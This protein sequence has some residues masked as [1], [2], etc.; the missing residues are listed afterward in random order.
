MQQVFNAV[1]FTKK[2]HVKLRLRVF[3]PEQAT[4]EF[5]KSCRF[6]DTDG[7]TEKVERTAPGLLSGAPPLTKLSGRVTEEKWDRLMEGGR[8][9]IP[10]LSMAEDDIE[11]TC[12][13]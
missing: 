9:E 6:E 7:D 1:K 11:D 2:G 5:F 13:G 12:E 3:K 8:R 10:E 4:L